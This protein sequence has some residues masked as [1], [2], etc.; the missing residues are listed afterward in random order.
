MNLKRTKEKEKTE[1]FDKF[2]KELNPGTPLS[3][4]ECIKYSE[5]PNPPGKNWKPQVVEVPV[6]ESVLFTDG[7]IVN[8]T[9]EF[10][11]NV[12]SFNID[13]KEQ[14]AVDVKKTRY[15][16]LSDYTYA[17]VYLIAKETLTLKKCGGIFDVVKKVSI[18]LKDKQD[19]EAIE[20]AKE[21]IQINS[22]NSKRINTS[23]IFSLAMSMTIGKTESCGEEVS[24]GIYL[25][26]KKSN[27]HI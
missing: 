12:N 21:V 18:Y 5:A 11:E 2:A 15:V 1:F 19:K 16:Y 6:V 23:S 13:D 27:R 3:L 24:K 8:V 4:V 22:N 25:V 26:K 17:V 7:N 14:K 9:D 20:K 10:V